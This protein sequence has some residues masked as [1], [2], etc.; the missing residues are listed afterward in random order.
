MASDMLALQYMPDR[1]VLAGVDD[2]Q[3]DPLCGLTDPCLDI[4]RDITALG[5]VRQRSSW[6]HNTDAKSDE[7]EDLHG[8]VLWNEFVA[9]ANVSDPDITY[10]F[11]IPV[12]LLF[13]LMCCVRVMVLIYDLFLFVCFVFLNI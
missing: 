1:L 11:V 7:S 10:S 6:S 12:S 9:M 4:A 13:C 5:E 2:M 3:S 8:D